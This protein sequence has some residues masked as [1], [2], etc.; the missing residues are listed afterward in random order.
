MFLTAAEIVELTRFSKAKDQIRWL[1]DH[2]WTFVARADGSPVVSR[3]HMQLKLAPDAGAADPL[4]EAMFRKPS[5]YV[6]EALHLRTRELLRIK[7]GYST[8]PQSRLMTVRS[9]ERRIGRGGI[10]M[11][12]ALVLEHPDALAIERRALAALEY[13]NI[14]GEWFNCDAATAIAAVKKA[15]GQV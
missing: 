1:T 6:M 4:P 5:V 8:D 7:V 13:C 11:N 15:A 12:L 2:G 14:D 9:L 3:K 10:A